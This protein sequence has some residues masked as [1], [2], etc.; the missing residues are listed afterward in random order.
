MS[1][2]DG[3]SGLVV[4]VNN[5]AI[6]AVETGAFGAI[7]CATGSLCYAVG[8]NRVTAIVD[9]VTQGATTATR[10]HNIYSIDC[11]SPTRCVVLGDNP[12]PQ[13][14]FVHQAAYGIL[15]NGVVGRAYTI[16]ANQDFSFDKISCPSS[17]NCF[18]GGS[19]YG[20]EGILAR[21]NVNR[22][23][24]SVREDYVYGYTQDIG[25]GACPLATTCVFGG[26]FGLA[27]VRSATYM[28]FTGGAFLTDIN[29]PD[30]VARTVACA[31]AN[32]CYAA[33][34]SYLDSA[35]FLQR[36]SVG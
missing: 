8:G 24:H 35:G 4:P 12:N 10:F 15:T 28:N 6:G 5:G 14:Q 11:V 22:L 18:A 32:E 3:V 21:I 9:G 31:S 13:G 33:G 19:F 27:L 7:G 16:K 1:G 29:A 36:F 2:D 30:V 23:S 34:V 17:S 26:Y 25:T 20:E